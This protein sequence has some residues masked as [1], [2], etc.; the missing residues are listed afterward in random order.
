MNHKK[1]AHTKVKQLSCCVAVV[2][3]LIS[4]APFLSAATATQSHFDTAEQAANTMVEAL[5][6]HDEAKLRGLFGE[7]YSQIIP[8]NL[9]ASDIKRF[10][11]AW[12][13]SHELV[14]QD[15]AALTPE[16]EQ[17]RTLIVG[18]YK[19]ALPI[20]IAKGNDGWYFDTEAGL[21]N[22]RI[23]QIGTHELHVIQSMLAYHRAQMEYSRSDFDG[24]G[25]LEYA[26][27]LISSPGQKN[28]L[29]WV[30]ESGE[31]F[32]PLGSLFAKKTPEKA[33]HGY[34]YQILTGQGKHA[35]GGAY[36][37]LVNDNMVQGFALIAWPAEYAKSGIMSFM[38]NRDG[39]VFEADLGSNSKSASTTT[40]FNPDSDWTPVSSNYMQL[41]ED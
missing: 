13:Y 7:H 25:V 12:E 14:P 24:N 17:S 4:I 19:W 39:V 11:A 27:K 38:I 5:A 30:T 3:S 26:Q 20:P 34:Y 18:K 37:Y 28:G 31:K 15:S 1:S 9:D 6:Q 36:S 33:Y 35:E 10:V 22:I 21:D 29:Y 2:I 41:I 23:R 16:G 8:E 32:S 40:L